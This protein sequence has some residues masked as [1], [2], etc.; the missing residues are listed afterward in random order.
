[1]TSR[2]SSVQPIDREAA[3][4]ADVVGTLRDIG[5]LSHRHPAFPAAG[6]QSSA[7]TTASANIT[8]SGVRV[9]RVPLVAGNFLIHNY[10]TFQNNKGSALVGG[11]LLFTIPVGYRG[12]AASVMLWN[13]TASTYA[14]ANIA[15]TGLVTFGVGTI[16]NLD[17]CRVMATYET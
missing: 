9:A 8:A 10:G 6:D 5:L 15:S 3:W 16:A 4:L 17:S 11:D 1:M 14:S 2:G 12:T 7:A 13:I